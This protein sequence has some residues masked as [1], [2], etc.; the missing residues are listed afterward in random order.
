MKHIRSSL[1]ARLCAALLALLIVLPAAGAAIA[2]TYAVVTGTNSLNLRAD[3]NASSQWLGAY[4]KGSW[5]TV[6]GSQ[7]NFYFVATADGKTGY[8]S[9]NFL[10]TTEQLTYGNVAIVSN[11]KATAFLNLRAYPSYSAKVLGILYNGVPLTVLGDENGWYRTQ[12]GDTVGYVRGEYATISYQPIGT[13]VATI[14]TPNNTAVNMRVGPSASAAVRRQFA[15]DRYVSVLYK[16]N[17]WW[18]VCIDRYLGFISSDFLVEGLHAARDNAANQGGGDGERYAIVSNPVSSQKLNLRELPSTAATVIAKLGNG[19]RLSMIT[20]GTEWSRVY[21]DTLAAT[22]YVLTKY[23]SLYNLPVTPR[24]TIAHPNGSYVNMR[25]AASLAA[26]VVAR[27]PDGA[28]ATV[29]APGPDWTKV[30]YNSKVGYV[31]NYFTS[32]GAEE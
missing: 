5:V 16:G 12:L 3:A 24:L 31:L 20:Q 10:S 28:Q 6:T 29:V 2:E 22:G 19:Y 26:T 1:R 15:G 25:S 27:V 17:G 32:I 9:K 23:L 21:A 4:P 14:K 30:K 13:G 7:S 8:M 18:Y 11:A